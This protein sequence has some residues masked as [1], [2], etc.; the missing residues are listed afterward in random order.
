MAIGYLASTMTAGAVT[1]LALWPRPTRGPRATPAFVIESSANELPFLI[2][3]WLVGSTLLAVKEHDIPSLL[4]W[5][6]LG[7]A[8][9]TI[10]GLAVMVR[11]AFDARPVLTSALE[12]CVPSDGGQRPWLALGRVLIAPLRLPQRRVKRTRGVAYGPVSRY[13][14]LDLYC[15]RS[16]PA[17]CPV[18]VYFHPGGFVSGAK[19]RESRLLADRLVRRGWIYL[20]A[21]YRLGAAGEFPNHLID[22]KRVIAWVRAHGEELGVDQRLIV[23][24]GGSSGAHIAAICALTTNDPTFQPGFENADTSIAAAIGLYG[25]Y[26]AEPTSRTAAAPS[27][28]VRVDAA[29]LFAIHGRRDPMVP[30]ANARRFVEELSSVST[31][32]VLYAELPGAQH[33]FDR[34]ASIRFAAVVDAIDRF[35]SWVR[36]NR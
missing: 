6:A 12:Q 27:D 28:Y 26:G 1:S 23:L 17:S 15:R 13:N 3:Y 4:G 35:T 33:N 22:A 25:Y 31:S 29:P 2:F 8:L 19:S 7:I 32:P 10:I 24:A 18:F 16:R 5:I 30:Q 34:F 14:S 36:Y 9:L 11:R 20:S 21:N